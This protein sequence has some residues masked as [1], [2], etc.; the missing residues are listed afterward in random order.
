[1]LKAVIK[2]I[3]CSDH[4]IVAVS[5]KTKVPKAGPYIVYKRSY[6]M[7]CSDSYVDDVKNIC[8]S[9]VCNKQPGAALDT[10]MKCLFQLL[11][12]MRPLRKGL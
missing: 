5:R 11:I 1:M 7:F 6:N 8:W 3:E 2:A 12:S 4:N 9:V 10:F